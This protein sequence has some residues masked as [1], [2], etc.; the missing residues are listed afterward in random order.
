VD[1]EN[2]DSIGGDTYTLGKDL[3]LNPTA[4]RLIPALNPAFTFDCVT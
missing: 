1:A 4:W 3:L 2:V